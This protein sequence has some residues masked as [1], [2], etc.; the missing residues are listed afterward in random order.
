MM[1]SLILDVANAQLSQLDLQAVHLLCLLVQALGDMHAAVLRLTKAAYCQ[2]VANG[3]TLSSV[4]GH[5]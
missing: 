2:G 4:Q 5:K 3:K 1:A